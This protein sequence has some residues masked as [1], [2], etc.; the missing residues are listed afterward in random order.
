M[1]NPNEYKVG[2]TVYIL[3]LLYKEAC[4]EA[5]SMVF[6]KRGDECKIKEIKK[7]EWSN[8]IWFVLDKSGVEVYATSGDF[9]RMK[10]F[11]CNY[12]TF[13]RDLD[14]EKIRQL[15]GWY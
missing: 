10:H 11:D 1:D 8:K 3:R 5:P 2:E 6:A 9:T 4:S 14:N 13:Q 7:S 12:S 15:S